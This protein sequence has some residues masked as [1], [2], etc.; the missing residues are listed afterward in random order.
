MGLMTKDGYKLR[1]WE[2]YGEPWFGV[3]LTTTFHE[4]SC[5]FVK[6]M[7]WRVFQKAF[8]GIGFP[9]NQGCQSYNLQAGS[10]PCRAHIRPMRNCLSLTSLFVAATATA[11]QLTFAQLQL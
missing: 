9:L 10:R 5:M 1:K 4:P 2:A 11:V 6:F 8:K 3:S 7:M